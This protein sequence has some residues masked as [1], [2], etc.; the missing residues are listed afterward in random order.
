MTRINGLNSAGFCVNVFVRF[1]TPA[2][3]QSAF[4][5]HGPQSKY[6]C[7][8]FVR[9]TPPSARARAPSPDWSRWM[10][11]LEEVGGEGKGAKKL[12][13]GGFQG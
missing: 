7:L 1:K 3:I 11:C 10:E 9:I 6:T 4:H 13:L 8:G 12:I 2:E 5:L